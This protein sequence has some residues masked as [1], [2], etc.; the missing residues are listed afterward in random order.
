[1]ADLPAIALAHVAQL[2]PARI[3]TQAKACFSEALRAG[4]NGI[5]RLLSQF[6]EIAQ[7]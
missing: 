3:A 7:W 5:A 4:S 1:M 6:A 2:V